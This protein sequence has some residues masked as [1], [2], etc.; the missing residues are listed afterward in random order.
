MSVGLR[1]KRNNSSNKINSRSSGVM[2]TDVCDQ[3]R[4]EEPHFNTAEILWIAS[5]VHTNLL[6][7]MWLIQVMP[8]SLSTTNEIDCYVNGVL[9]EI[10]STVYKVKCALRG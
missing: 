6:Q 5:S 9:P 8:S 2:K 1:Q 4:D 3:M 10:I 7:E